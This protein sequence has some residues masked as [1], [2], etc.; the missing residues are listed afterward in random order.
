MYKTTLSESKLVEKDH[1]IQELKRA[2]AE[3]Q[4]SQKKE[5]VYVSRDK[6]RIETLEGEIKRLKGMIENQKTKI[7]TV[8]RESS[9]EI[10]TAV[11]HATQLRED[12]DFLNFRL[13]KER[14]K[15]ETYNLHLQKAETEI[16]RL[17]G[18]NDRL[19]EDLKKQKH[20]EGDTT[21]NRRVAICSRCKS[22]R[23]ND[24]G[25]EEYENGGDQGEN[26]S[27]ISVGLRRHSSKASELRARLFTGMPLPLHTGRSQADDASHDQSK[28]LVS[29]SRDVSNMDKAEREKALES[30]RAIKNRIHHQLSNTDVN[31]TLGIRR[32][33]LGSNGASKPVFDFESPA[34]SP[35]HGADRDWSTKN[36]SAMRGAST[37]QHK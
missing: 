17:E 25:I 1:Q 24:G 35:S 3:M 37:L 36:V 6:Q 20:G 33:S 7:E 12:C 8:I 19:K 26:K 30:Q 11:Q 23:R 14:I 21:A 10:R 32:L 5:A 9:R 18:E 29:M 15:S 28:S 22:E 16:Q 34:S 4:R 31:S 13:D 27:Q 2:L